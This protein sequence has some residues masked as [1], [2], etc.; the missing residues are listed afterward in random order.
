MEQLDKILDQ[1]ET[2]GAEMADAFIVSRR[3]LTLSVRDGQVESIKRASPG[4]LGIRYFAGGKMA[5]AHSTDLSE[6]SVNS[7]VPRLTNMAR[8]TEKDPY[9]GMPGPSEYP[10]NLDILDN[11]QFDRPIEEKIEYLKSL[12]R[13]ALKYH[14]S[15]TKSNGVFYEEVISTRALANSKGV[16]FSYES[17]FYRVGISVVASKNEE[18]FPGEGGMYAAIFKDIP[19]PEKIV[20]Y[21]ASQAVQLVGG[22]PVEPGDYEIVFTPRSAGSIYWGL[23]FALNGNNCF[24]GASFLADKIGKRIA[25]DNFTLID[26]AVM[27]RGISSRPVDDEGTP[28]QK[29]ILIENG[30]IKNFLYDYKTALKAKLSST[31]SAYRQDYGST[32]EINPTNFYIAPGKDNFDDVVATLKKGIIVEQT[33][34][35]GLHSVTGQYSAGINGILV[36][37]GKRIRPVAGVT[38]AASADEI[39]MGIGAVCDDIEFHWDMTSPSL[40][41]KQMRVGA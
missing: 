36:E 3:T 38:L 27:P 30:I 26:N 32:P 12:E 40:M 9:A 10:Q 5:F 1:C 29:T 31:G 25:S 15:I 33:Q 14:P 8:K 23:N 16:R 7:I 39:L 13:L 41:I 22:T 4:G 28:S 34:G 37:N 2:A 35:W 11:K 21:Y 19:P 6:S 24:K 20:D 18:M 17:S